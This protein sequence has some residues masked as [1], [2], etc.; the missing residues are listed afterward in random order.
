MIASLT[1]AARLIGGTVAAG[2]VA[3]A[4]GGLGARVV[5]WLVKVG[6]NSHNGAV[7]HDGYEV[8]RLTLAGTAS[9]MIVGAFY[10]VPSAAI[11]YLLVRR[12]LPGRGW[13]K[14]LWFGLWLLSWAG[15]FV[16]DVG[17]HEHYRYGSPAVSFALFAALIPLT[18]VVLATLA[19]WW[20]RGGH[21]P[22]DN[23]AVR[24]GGRGF[25]LVTGAVGAWFEVQTLRSVAHA[26]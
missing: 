1:R 14:G 4:V 15:R 6:N 3:G 16:I 24:W 8:G 7:T 22:I 25:L 2:A 11:L 5:M 18:A 13:Q 23:R 21:T 19:E 20:G 9:L 10:V 17:S 26:F 12:W